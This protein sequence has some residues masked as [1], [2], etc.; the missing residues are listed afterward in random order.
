[1]LGALAPRMGPLGA[2]P[3]EK[4][5][6]IGSK[7]TPLVP[8]EQTGQQFVNLSTFRCTDL[9]RNAVRPEKEEL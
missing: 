7:D 9:K 2:K 5:R 8:H 6:G 3:V 1:M 4:R